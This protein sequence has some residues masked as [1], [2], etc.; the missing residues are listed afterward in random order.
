MVIPAHG[1]EADLGADGGIG[2]AALLGADVSE[3]IFLL[4]NVPE[5]S[6]GW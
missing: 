6:R 5:E 1:E 4:W 2:Y 3:L